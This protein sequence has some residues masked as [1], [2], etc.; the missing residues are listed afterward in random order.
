MQGKK[1]SCTD[2]ILEDDVIEETIT[3]FGNEKG[4]LVVQP[5]GYLVVEFLIKHFRIC[6]IMRYTKQ[7]EDR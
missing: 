6:L 3:R 1:I 2:Y 4:K 5:T 7:M